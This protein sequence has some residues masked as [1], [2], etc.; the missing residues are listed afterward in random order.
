MNQGSSR[1]HG[2]NATQEEQMTGQQTAE[3]AL[4]ELEPLIG[5]WTLEATPPGGPAW[6]GEARATFGW[7]EGD[8]LLIG[9]TTIELPEAPSTI[10]VIGCD[11][12]GGTYSQLYSDDRGV[13]RIYEMNIGGGE[14]KLWRTGEPFDQR[15]TGRFSDDG[16]AIHGRWETGNDGEWETDF[17]LVYT[18]IR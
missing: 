14:W 8:Q 6:P 15:F 2:G 9:R 11:A 13:C 4:K 16:D 1:G 18:R 10:S 5:E 12:A 7:L 17:D 3:N